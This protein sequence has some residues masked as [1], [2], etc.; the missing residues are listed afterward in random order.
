MLG[1][2][3]LTVL[4]WIYWAIVAAGVA[5]VLIRYGR[6]I[7][8]AAH[9][10]WLDV[11]SLLAAL[12]GGRRRKPH[13]AVA[14]AAQ[15]AEKPALPFASFS[16]PFESQRHLTAGQLVQYTFTA[17]EAWGRERNC[18]RSPHHTAFEFARRVGRAYPDMSTTT[19]YL[20]DLYGR[21]MFAPDDLDRVSI[22]QLKSLWEQMTGPSS[23][24][25]T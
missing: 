7:L 22:V 18:P 4:R 23:R 5:F 8:A 16:N 10:F 20:A 11:L 9:K 6:V 21:A 19:K 1:Q 24:R 12:W 14:E 13:L 2:G 25:E 17:L 3:L 15:P